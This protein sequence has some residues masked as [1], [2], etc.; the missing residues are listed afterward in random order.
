MD[1][2]LSLTDAAEFLGLHFHT[3]RRLARAGRLEER[4]VPWKG[5]STRYVCEYGRTSV[6]AHRALLA[7]QP[8]AP[9]PAEWMPILEA[10]ALLKMTR[11]GIKRRIK[12][13][14]LNALHHGT[15]APGTVTLYVSRKQVEEHIEK[16]P[17]YKRRTDFG[18]IQPEE[19]KWIWLAGFFDGEGCVQIAKRA[20]E[21]R[22][23]VLSLSIANTHLETLNTLIADF[24]GRM[25]CKPR[26]ED[27]HKDCWYWSATGDEA[28]E[29]LRRLLPN[30]RV[31]RLQA[32]IG[33]EFQE[34]LRSKRYGRWDRTTDEELEW[35]EDARLRLGRLNQRGKPKPGL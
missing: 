6:E 9:D 16:R 10:Q 2:W 28:M 19:R 27:W 30:L 4:R 17:A 35:R 15:P 1:E 32:E 21:E 12:L 13:G 25:Y 24:G 34:R 18:D 14:L 23:W 33:I 22:R 8:A 5:S 3:V 26:A 7:A 31:K 11:H 20:R 29:V